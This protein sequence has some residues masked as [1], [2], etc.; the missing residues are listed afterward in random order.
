MKVTM[1]AIEVFDV[2]TGKSKKPSLP[3]FTNETEKDGQIL[4]FKNVSS[5][6]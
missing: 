5:Y 6:Q 3:K 1:N 2:V 4:R